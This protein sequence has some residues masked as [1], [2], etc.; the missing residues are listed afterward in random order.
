MTVHQIVVA[1]A[2]HDAVTNH[3][4]V[5]RDALRRRGPSE[6]FARFVHDDLAGDARPL[7]A[8]PTDP[9]DA[10][11]VHASIGEMTLTE[12]L[13]NRSEPL[14]LVYHNITPPEFFDP[15]DARVA[16][17]LRQGREELAVLRDRVAVALGVSEF[18]AAELRGLGFAD[19]GVVP[20][21]VP[22]GR[23]DV[24]PD[25]GAADRLAAAGGPVFLSVGQVLP[26]KRPDFLLR[27]FHILRTYLAPGS[28]LVLAG[29]ERSP[30]YARA[31]HQL[32]AELALPD[33]WFAGDVSDSVLAALYRG[34][35]ALVTASEH[36]GFCAP[37]VEAMTVGLPV[38]ARRFAAL[39]E[40]LDGAGILLE[41]ADGP[42]VF[43]E[44][45]LAASEAGPGSVRDALVAAGQRR[46]MEL[47]AAD[48]VG[49]FLDALD[50]AIGAGAGAGAAS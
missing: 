20:L 19:V 21:A 5:L 22:L 16:G 50:G 15:W 32:A 44:A 30:R 43:A 41:A 24:E 29:A 34:A 1:A 25:P 12:V 2:P 11:V 45:M 6:L 48:P 23:L 37:V 39:P 27:A 9:V 8:L 31:V 40:T 17:E 18:N 33:V 46:A 10:L 36:E 4:L 47:A 28:G 3:A 38:V 13:L 35:T 49:S 14:V 26:H 42:A 7:A